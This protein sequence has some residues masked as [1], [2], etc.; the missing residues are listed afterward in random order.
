M[1]ITFKVSAVTWSSNWNWI[2]TADDACWRLWSMIDRD[3]DIE[4]SKNAETP[5]AAVIEEYIVPAS[6]TTSAVATTR[7]ADR[8]AFDILMINM[9]YCI[10]VGLNV[11]GHYRRKQLCRFRVSR[12]SVVAHRCEHCLISSKK[13]RNNYERLNIVLHI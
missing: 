7:Y 9:F 3:C 8:Y 4:M 13:H 6:V 12:S 10:L 1:I 5:D 2:V 11:F